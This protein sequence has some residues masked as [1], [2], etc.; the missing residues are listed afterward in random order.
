VKI[1]SSQVFYI[2]LRLKLIIMICPECGFIGTDK[3][4]VY[5]D[6]ELMYENGI[7]D[8]QYGGVLVEVVVLCCPN[9]GG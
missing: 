1:F 2:N 8:P 9:C 6:I 3:E 7:D 5:T 4:P